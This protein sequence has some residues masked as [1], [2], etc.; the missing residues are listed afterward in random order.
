MNPPQTD[1]TTKARDEENP[2]ST[3][4]EDIQLLYLLTLNEYEFSKIMFKL[5]HV[6]R[7]CHLKGTNV[8]SSVSIFF[9]NPIFAYNFAEIMKKTTI[10]HREANVHP[11]INGGKRLIRFHMGGTFS[12]NLEKMN[13][14]P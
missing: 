10:I 4:L 9:F 11:Q 13:I 12:G 3:F 5:F 14:G 6:S 8:I 7:Y 2:I 1:H